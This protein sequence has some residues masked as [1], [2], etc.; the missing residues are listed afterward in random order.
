MLFQA[1]IGQLYEKVTALDLPFVIEIPSA[2]EDLPAA[3][4]I[5]P[6]G[7]CETS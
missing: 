4:L 6:G 2:Y 1:R 5:L 3:S 7:I